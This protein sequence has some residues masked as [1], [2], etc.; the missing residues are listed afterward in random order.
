MLRSLSNPPQH[1]VTARVYVYAAYRGV[2]ARGPL[3]Q[4]GLHRK[5]GVNGPRRS[6]ALPKEL[7]AE[8]DQTHEERSF[9]ISEKKKRGW[10]MTGRRVGLSKLTCN[11]Q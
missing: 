9:G 3:S 1:A 11:S 4:P 6:E 2:H 5:P 10:D 7:L 8:I